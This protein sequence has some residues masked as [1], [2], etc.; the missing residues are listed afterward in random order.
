MLLNSRN[1][2][3]INFLYHP[4]ISVEENKGKEFNEFK[5]NFK[6]NNFNKFYEGFSELIQ[7]HIKSQKE[8]NLILL[9]QQ[10]S[11]ELNKMKE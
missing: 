11:F 2:D 1:K 6:E 8:K 9:S 10:K 5:L 3:N 4:I 7:N